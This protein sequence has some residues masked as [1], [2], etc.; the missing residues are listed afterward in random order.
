MS[1]VNEQRLILFAN[2]SLIFP[3]IYVKLLRFLNYFILIFPPMAL[4]LRKRNEIRLKE[5]GE[6]LHVVKMGVFRGELDPLGRRPL[7]IISQWS[8]VFFGIRKYVMK[9]CRE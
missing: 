2:F 4:F 1:P 3:Y 7:L 5:S 8:V 9:S 6:R